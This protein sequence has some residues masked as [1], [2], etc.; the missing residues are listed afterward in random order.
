MIKGGDRMDEKAFALR[1]AILRTEKNV[2][3]RDMSLS[4]GQ[5]PG[6]INNIESG[7]AMPSLAG[8]FYI[9]EYLGITPSDISEDDAKHY[10]VPVGVLVYQIETNNSSYKAGLRRGDIIVEFAGK[11]VKDSNGLRNVLASK[12]AGELVKIKVYRDSA[13]GGEYMEFEFKLDAR[14]Q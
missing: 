8:I 11:E 12:K 9:C 5:N 2:S 6:Y 4:M 3:A 1:L 14:S 7:K 13:E 10:N